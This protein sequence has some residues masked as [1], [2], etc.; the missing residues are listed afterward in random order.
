M[1]GDLELKIWTGARLDRWTLP[2][3]GLTFPI[4]S[5]STSMYFEMN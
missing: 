1:G 5:E 2:G 4:C 3:F